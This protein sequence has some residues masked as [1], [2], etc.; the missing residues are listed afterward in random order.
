[1]VQVDICDPG[2]DGYLVEGASASSSKDRSS[3][4]QP[5]PS[6][7]DAILMSSLLT[8]SSVP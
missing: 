2:E 5:S 7:S 3:T 4:R 1:M 8:S 6:D